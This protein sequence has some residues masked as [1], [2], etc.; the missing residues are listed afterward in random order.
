M[1]ESRP[2]M[3]RLFIMGGSS[4]FEET[5]GYGTTSDPYL[6]ADRIILTRIYQ[7]D[8]DCDVFLP[9]FASEGSWRRASYEEFVAWAN[10]GDFKI[11]KGIQR[12]GD[13][14]FEIQMWVK[15]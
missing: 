3:H 4:L 8:Y 10:V 7:P 12:E 2:D 5:L 9:N 11:P 1:L 14:K 15:A 6:L 13:A